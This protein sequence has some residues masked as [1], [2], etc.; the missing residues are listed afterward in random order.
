VRKEKIGN[1]FVEYYGD[2]FS[3]IFLTLYFVYSFCCASPVNHVILPS[4]P[5]FS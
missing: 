4:C 2:I 3:I 1:I 5:N